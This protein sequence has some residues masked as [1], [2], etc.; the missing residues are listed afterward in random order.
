MGVAGY[1]GVSECGRGWVGSGSKAG[2]K[3]VVGCDG[4][5]SDDLAF[6]TLLRAL[7]ERSDQ[8]A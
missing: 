2:S 7:S 8:R 4:R 1:H 6:K 5:A 3:G